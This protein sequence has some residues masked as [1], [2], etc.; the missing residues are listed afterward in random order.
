MMSKTRGFFS[1]FLF[2]LSYFFSSLIVP[3]CGEK[4]TVVFHCHRWVIHLFQ[5]VTSRKEKIIYPGTEAA[6]FVKREKL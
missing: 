1:H 2:L 3:L 4:E 6:L 5:C